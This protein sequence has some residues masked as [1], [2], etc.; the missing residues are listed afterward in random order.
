ME[1]EIWHYNKE[2]R[3]K[4][5]VNVTIQDFNLG[6]EFEILGFLLGISN[7]QDQG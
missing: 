3:N 6:L 1:M 5:K 7:L 2:E 4:K